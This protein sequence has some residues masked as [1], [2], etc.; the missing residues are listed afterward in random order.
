MSIDKQI[1]NILT[2]KKIDDLASVQ[3]TYFDIL[4][5]YSIAKNINDTYFNRILFYNYIYRYD[6]I[7]FRKVIEETNKDNMRL[8]FREKTEFGLYI[9]FGYFDLLKIKY[10]DNEKYKKMYSKVHS[11][12]ND[13]DDEIRKIILNVYNEALAVNKDSYSAFIC[14]KKLILNNE[15]I[16]VLLPKMNY[17][18]DKFIEKKPKLIRIIYNEALLYLD[19][20]LNEE[21][22]ELIRFI[23]KGLDE[24]IISLPKNVLLINQLLSIFVTSLIERYSK[25]NGNR[26]LKKSLYFLEN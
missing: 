18:L 7:D 25:N 15:D 11:E 21:Y 22:K 1:V 2:N 16:L 17:S 23:E 3:V 12:N 26:K 13:F 24:E 9:M 8:L 14:V 4:E 10:T 5:Y 20:N 6:E 19:N